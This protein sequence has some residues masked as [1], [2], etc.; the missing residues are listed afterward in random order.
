MKLPI[1]LKTILDP[2]ILQEIKTD[3]ISVALMN[4]N[5]RR[6]W[7]WSIYEE[8]KSINRDIHRHLMADDLDKQFRASSARLQALQWVLNQVL[9]SKNSV[10]LE[11]QNRRVDELDDV[12]VYRA[13]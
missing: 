5:V 9:A 12:T 13:P 1:W 8:M 4:V 2:S 3:E 7:L 6:H 10:E 11:N